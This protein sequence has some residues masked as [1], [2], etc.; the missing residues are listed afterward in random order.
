MSLHR[1]TL[2]IYTLKSCRFFSDRKL[3][4]HQMALAIFDN[5]TAVGASQIQPD[6]TIRSSVA[7]SAKRSSDFP[8]WDL[9]RELVLGFPGRDLSSFFIPNNH[10][11][12]CSSQCSESS[13][14]GPPRP[15]GS[16]MASPP[17][18]LRI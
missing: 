10:H 6:R 3:D 16:D 9:S 8:T 7:P 12:P 17:T 11:W 4:L 14:V 13:S 15:S 18:T 5:R 1:A 2:S